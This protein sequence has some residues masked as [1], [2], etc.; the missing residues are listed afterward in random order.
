[1]ANTLARQTKSPGHR[2]PQPSGLPSTYAVGQLLRAEL[3]EVRG[4]TEP[5]AIA[6]AALLARRRIRAKFN[7]GCA[8]VSSELPLAQ[9]EVICLMAG[10]SLQLEP[11]LSDL[12][13]VAKPV[14]TGLL[15]GL[16]LVCGALSV[17]R[18]LHQ[19]LHNDS[20]GGHHLC[21]VCMFA[22]GQASAADVTLVTAL[23]VLCPL[24]SLC[25]TDPSPLSAFDYRLSP[26]R[27]PPPS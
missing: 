21:L 18:A 13:R 20:G 15:A 12:R 10:V 16:L 14:L 2:A 26:S 17:S 6:Y 4:C 19:S 24:I 11:R 9:T 3:L 23:L 8:R 7:F 22:K 27:A 1:M 5:A 25:A